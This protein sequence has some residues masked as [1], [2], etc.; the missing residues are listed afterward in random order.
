VGNW[1]ALRHR[2]VQHVQRYPQE[3]QAAEAGKPPRECYREDYPVCA[4][5][6]TFSLRCRMCPWQEW[7]LPMPVITPGAAAEGA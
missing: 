4:N 2:L 1:R 6:D 3:A 5:R 7:A